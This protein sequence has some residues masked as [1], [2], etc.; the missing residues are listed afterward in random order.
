M[1][2]L[3][4]ASVAFLLIGLTGCNVSKIETAE[5]CIER[6]KDLGSEWKMMRQEELEPTFTYDVSQMDDPF[7]SI[8]GGPAGVKGAK[9]I[10]ASGASGPALEA[11]YKDDV[12][13]NGALF[14]GEDISLYRVRG[15]MGSREQTIAAG[16]RS[17]PEKARL[18]HIAWTP[19][20]AEASN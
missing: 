9:M 19:Y 17:A 16:C 11:F 15:S 8:Y 5:Q 4:P 2:Q 1:R 18:I 6:F 3:G 10:V 20:Y 7:F 14:A 13:S 12:P